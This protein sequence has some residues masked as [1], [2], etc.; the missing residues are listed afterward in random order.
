M[1]TDHPHSQSL[2]NHSILDDVITHARI[3]AEEYANDEAK[4]ILPIIM[5]ASEWREKWEFAWNSAVNYSTE[6]LTTPQ[7]FPIHEELF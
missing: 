5:P 6:G 7:L 4:A 3:F 1:Q 2:T